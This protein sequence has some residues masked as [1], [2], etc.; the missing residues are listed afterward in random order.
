LHLQA[1]DRLRPTPLELLQGLEHRKARL[2]DASLHAALAPQGRLAGR[3]TGQIGEVIPVP[4]RRLLGH[5]RML[6]AH[7]GQLQI[8]QLFG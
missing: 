3:Q 6:L 5:G 7:E 8:R 2:G 1:V 4:L